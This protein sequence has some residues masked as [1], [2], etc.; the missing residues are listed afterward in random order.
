MMDVTA[1]HTHGSNRDHCDRAKTGERVPWKVFVCEGGSSIGRFVLRFFEVSNLLG[2]VSGCIRT[3]ASILD[4]RFV[5]M[6]LAKLR[7]LP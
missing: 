6:D 3:T 1:S 7:L 4:M 2:L 5:A